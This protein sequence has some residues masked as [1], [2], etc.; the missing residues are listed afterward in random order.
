METRPAISAPCRANAAPRTLPAKPSS[1][2]A[3]SSRL[4][5]DSTLV[6]SSPAEL[7]ASPAMSCRAHGKQTWAPPRSNVSLTDA[8]YGKCRHEHL[9]RRS[10]LSACGPPRL[11]FA[12]RF[13]RNGPRYDMLG[14]CSWI[15]TRTLSFPSCEDI[16]RIAHPHASSAFTRPRDVSIRAP[17]AAPL[18]AQF[19]CSLS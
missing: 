18:T 4:L 7:V 5:S 14:A 9:P 15:S 13:T 19:A 6:T 10:A 11:R 8:P 17:A 2:S 1:A 12:L 3:P 16:Y